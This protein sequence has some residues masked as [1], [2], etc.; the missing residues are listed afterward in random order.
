MINALSYTCI[1]VG[2]V[3]WF[4]GTIPL[5]GHRSVLFK[6]HSLSVADTLGSMSIIVGLLLKIPSEWPLLILAI[7]SLA[8]WNTVLGYVLA[9]CSS[10]GGD[11]D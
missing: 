11:N 9:Y 5:I 6:L 10:S 2:I 1:G 4:W 7:I 8:I 3:F